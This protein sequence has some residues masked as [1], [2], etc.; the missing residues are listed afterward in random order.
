MM[1]PLAANRWSSP[2]LRPSRRDRRWWR[3]SNPGLGGQ[4]LDKSVTNGIVSAIE[5]EVDGRRY[6]QTTAAINPGNSGGPL[7]DLHGRVVGVVSA[8]AIKQENIGFAVSV[9]F[10]QALFQER[11]GKFKVEGPFTAWEEKIPG[12][13]LRVQP[14]AMA[15]DEVVVDLKY[16][17]ETKLLVAALPERNKVAII[18]PATGKIVHEVFAG[19]DPA[20]IRLVGRGKAWVSHLSSKNVALI[21]IRSGKLDRKMTL[22]EIPVDFAASQSAIWFMSPTGILHMLTIADGIDHWAPVNIR[23]LLCVNL[24]NHLFCGSVDGGLLEVDGDS[25]GELMGPWDDVAHELE[26][27][28]G[29]NGV[30]VTADSAQYP[31]LARKQAKLSDDIKK[32]IRYLAK[33]PALNIIMMPVSRQLLLFDAKNA[34]LL[35]LRHV[36]R[37]VAGQDHRHLQE[38]RAY[39]ERAWR[40]RGPV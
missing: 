9:S 30:R 29:G 7:L 17:A 12:M 10:V 37:Q 14:G 40:S 1:P 33:A 21:D 8:K 25:L 4:I 11:A 39:H 20:A 22:T 32:C 6:I 31:A 26:A 16:D 34:P 35:Q 27:Y 24:K 13:A 18:N 36:R 19:T 23:S 38:S 2:I 28:Q 15:I 5:R 3:S